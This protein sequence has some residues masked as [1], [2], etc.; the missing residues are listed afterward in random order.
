M[1]TPSTFGRVVVTSH[2]QYSDAAHSRFNRFPRPSPRFATE[3]STMFNAAVVGAKKRPV[4]KSGKLRWVKEKEG[5]SER[6]QVKEDSV[7]SMKKDEVPDEAPIR[8]MTSFEVHHVVGRSPHALERAET[9]SDMVPAGIVTLGGLAYPKAGPE[10]DVAKQPLTK[11]NRRKRRDPELDQSVLAT[12]PGKDYEATGLVWGAMVEKKDG[13]GPAGESGQE[14]HASDA[15]WQ[16]LIHVDG[17]CGPVVARLREIEEK[18]FDLITGELLTPEQQK[19]RLP[20]FVALGN[21]RAVIPSTMKLEKELNTRDKGYN[22]LSW[23]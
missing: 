23:T 9:P 10:E 3:Y 8:D 6:Q 5:P 22:I 1:P 17:S 14:P 4:L 21:Q 11:E 2:P 7:P 13:H 20:T 12:V 19:H 16:K 18:K 15:D